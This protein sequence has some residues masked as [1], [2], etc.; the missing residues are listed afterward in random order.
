MLTQQE[1]EEI[2]RSV[3]E[4]MNYVALPVEFHRVS[5]TQAFDPLYQEAEGGQ[6]DW[7]TWPAIGA[8]VRFKPDEEFLT[9]AGVR[10]NADILVFVPRGA[11]QAWEVEHGRA[12][13][14]TA[15]MELSFNGLRFSVDREPRTDPLPML[16]SGGLMGQD[17]IGMVILG[18]TKA[19]TQ[20]EV[21]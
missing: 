7:E 15:G 16:L 14:V 13:E 1:F 6:E 9:K 10:A 19:D 11:V 17:Y 21:T 2:H 20:P 3:L 5:A 18:S 8:S 12:F 4:A